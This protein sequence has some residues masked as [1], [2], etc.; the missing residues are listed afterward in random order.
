MEAF[1]TTAEYPDAKYEGDTLTA[2]YSHTC[3]HH[4]PAQVK[5][6][7]QLF[8]RLYMVSVPHEDTFRRL[9]EFALKRIA[10]MN[11]GN[12]IMYPPD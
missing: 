7:L 1:L 10:G 6:D 3:S 11:L 9:S 2:L 8:V 4:Y 12:G 5:K